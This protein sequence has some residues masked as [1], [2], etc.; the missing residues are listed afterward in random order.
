MV[1]VKERR[2]YVSVIVAVA[3][4]ALVI[5]IGIGIGI[6]RKSM[7]YMKPSDVEDLLRLGMTRSEVF[8]QLPMTDDG[9]LPEFDYEVDGEM[10]TFVHPQSSA[11]SAILPHTEYSFSKSK[12][13]ND[14]VTPKL[15]RSH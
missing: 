9:T 5:L 11:V 12:D 4:I 13:E 3:S 1:S 2:V 15:L 7:Q 8:D 10:V 6:G 14:F